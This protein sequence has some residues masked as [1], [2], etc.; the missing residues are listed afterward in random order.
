MPE[1]LGFV[2]SRRTKAVLGST[3]GAEIE[4]VLDDVWMAV[5]GGE[6]QRGAPVVVRN[7]D[8]GASPTAGTL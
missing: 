8:E 4:E 6:V 7:V 1:A 5:C 2:E 3:V